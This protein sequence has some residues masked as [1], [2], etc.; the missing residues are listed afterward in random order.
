MMMDALATTSI[1]IVIDFFSDEGG[2]CIDIDECS[3]GDS[4]FD[5]ENEITCNCTTGFIGDIS[6]E[7][8]VYMLV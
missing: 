2:V 8:R 7:G 5:D 3:V 1:A 4:N 6:T